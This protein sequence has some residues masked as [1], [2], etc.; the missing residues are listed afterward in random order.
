MSGHSLRIW[1]STQS[2][3]ATS[4]AEA[5]LHN[6]VARASRGLGLAVDAPRNGSTSSL[7]VCSK[8]NAFFSSGNWVRARGN[9]CQVR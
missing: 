3:V 4:S 1:S 9:D 7:G 2:V 5:E 8:E 6:V